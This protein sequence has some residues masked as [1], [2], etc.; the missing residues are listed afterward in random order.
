[1]KGLQVRET[2]WDCYGV[3]C[4]MGSDACPHHGSYKQNC[5]SQSKRPGLR[6]YKALRLQE[7]GFQDLG[8]NRA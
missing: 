8:L 1:M 3:G 4:S 7:L 2:P 5:R 6:V